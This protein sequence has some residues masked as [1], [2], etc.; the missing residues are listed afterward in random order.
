MLYLSDDSLRVLGEVQPCE[1]QYLP[2]EQCDLVLP[3]AIADK[4]LRV[5]VECPTV[6][7]D[8]HLLLRKPNVDLLAT[9]WIIRPP[10]GDACLA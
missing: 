3:I 9:D 10:P 6:D 4:N 8:G 1:A 5:A 7:F 2:A